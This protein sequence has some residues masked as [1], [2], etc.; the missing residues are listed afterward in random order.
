MV[1]FFECLIV[2]ISLDLKTKSLVQ[3]A[4][5]KTAKIETISLADFSELDLAKLNNGGLLIFPINHK[6]DLIHYWDALKKHN[7]N[8]LL[9]RKL[10]LVKNAEVAISLKFDN[11][12]DL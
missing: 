3:E 10:L 11:S 4:I 7:K 5:G 1:N 2:Y 12:F 6:D 9:F 8:T